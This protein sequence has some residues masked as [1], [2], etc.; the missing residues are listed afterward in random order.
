MPIERR[1]ES[2]KRAGWC[3]AIKN[4]QN[5]ARLEE[6]RRLETE[7]F[8]AAQA[9]ANNEKLTGKT[10]VRAAMTMKQEVL[11]LCLPLSPT[12]SNLFI[13]IYTGSAVQPTP[14]NRLEFCSQKKIVL[15][16]RRLPRE[17]QQPALI[18]LAA[19][20]NCIVIFLE[21]KLAENQA[22]M[23]LEHTNMDG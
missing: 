2:E 12:P 14:S 3:E 1:K 13:Q 10:A 22:L 23:S 4:S 11:T 8:L 17:K 6:E 7:W 9:L 20:R 16:S 21:L 15:N 18:L 5:V 19:Y